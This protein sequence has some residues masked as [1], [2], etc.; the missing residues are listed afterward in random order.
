MDAALRRLVWRRAKGR[1]EY[2]QLPQAG[3]DRPFEIDRVIS[4]KHRGPTVAG[5]LAPSCFRCNS[6]KGSDISRR[7]EKTRKPAPLFNPRRHK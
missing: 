6:F 2:C 3:D 4:R 5:N 7:D 1:C